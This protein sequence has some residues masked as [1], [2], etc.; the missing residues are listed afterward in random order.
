M[1]IELIS[2]IRNNFIRCIKSYRLLIAIIALSILFLFP[3]LS[4]ES[5]IMVVSSYI[6]VLKSNAFLLAI[7]LC[8]IPYADS[9][10]EDVENN[11]YRFE[12]IRNRLSTFV[13]SKVTVILISAI[14]TMLVGTVLLCFLLVFRY[15]WGVSEDYRF[16]LSEVSSVFRSGNLVLYV[17][18]S[19]YQ[20]GVLCGIL[21]LLSAYISLFVRNKLM[22]YATPVIM[23]CLILDLLSKLPDQYKV[24]D[25]YRVFTP[26]YNVWNDD[27][28][29]FI[30]LNVLG[31]ALVVILYTAI[32]AKIKEIVANG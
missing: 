27:L 32:Y 9:I 2:G 5:D 18:M 14:L 3:I 13:L 11:Y 30:W 28:L 12:L 16:I 25:I 1:I 4:D 22:I 19:A 29:S 15:E 23:W 17:L 7:I 24:L 6:E 8:S 31:I 26:T 10:R 20:T 21:A